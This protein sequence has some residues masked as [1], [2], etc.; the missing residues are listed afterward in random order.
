MATLGGMTPTGRR[1]AGPAADLVELDSD[2]GLKHTAI[3][4]HEEHRSHVAL[5]QDLKGGLSFLER[6]MV[7]GLAELSARDVDQAAFIYPTG[8]IWS[9]AEVVRAMADQGQVCGVRAGLEMCYL[10]AQVLQEASEAGSGK[11]VRTHSGLSPWRLAFRADGQV[12]VLGYGL[13]MVEILTFR[14]HESRVP[15]EDSFRYCPPERLEG[16]P[17]DVSSDLFSLALVGFELMTGRPVYDGLVSDI[18]QQAI[19]AEGG[20]RL[21]QQREQLSDGVREV[22]GRALKYDPD[23]RY[24]NGAEFVYAVHDLLSAPGLDGVGLME[25]MQKVRAA[26][27]RGKALVGGKTGAISKEQLAA[28]REELQEP[29]RRPLPPPRLQRPQVAEPEPEPSGPSPRWGRGVRR[30]SGEGTPAPTPERGASGDDSARPPRR[31]GDEERP[32][33]RRSDDDRPRRLLRRGEETSPRAGVPATPQDIPVEEPRRSAPAPAEALLERLRTSQARD[34]EPIATA[35]AQPARVAA[36]EAVRSPEPPELAPPSEPSRAT[37]PARPSEPARSE[38][39]RPEPARA[40][41][42]ARPSEPARATP[43]SAQRVDDSAFFQVSVDG[44]EP[45]RTR[46]KLSEPLAETA[47]RL[48]QALVGTPTDLLGNVTGWYRL[49]QEGQTWRGDSTVR[50]LDPHRTVFLTWVPNRVLRVAFDID[51]PPERL[52]FQA[53]VGCAVPVRSLLAHLQLWLGLPRGGY[54]LWVEGESLGPLQ[55]LQEFEP[56]EGFQVLVKR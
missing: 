18:R 28:F 26:P 13:P 17:E 29:E 19:R 50:V 45:Q 20:R 14:Q 27:K 33:L 48:M 52:R 44:A 34:R 1:I 55:I 49:A 30:G 42:P 8:T 2:K 24:P 10:A 43:T 11:G 38:P 51:A 47:H 23:G 22:L 35:E 6:P 41:E 37:E 25:I 7:T 56:A 12:Q 21:Y 39:A 15:R 46:L 9:A 31:S 36:P 53:P 5:H 4:F 3:V 16:G 54:N 40:P 32:S